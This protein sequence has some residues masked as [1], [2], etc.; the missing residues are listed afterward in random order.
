MSIVIERVEAATL[1]L[2]A[3]LEAHHQDMEHAS[4]PESRHALH[5]DG[6]LTPQVRLFA[7]YDAAGR[8]VATGALATLDDD[9]EE[10]KSMR[11]DPAVRGQGYGSAMLD[12]LRADA[13]VR[14][15]RRLS[16]ETGSADFFLRADAEVRGIRRLSLETGSADFFLPARSLYARAGF[17]ECGPFGRYEADPYSTFMTL[18]LPASSTAPPAHT[19]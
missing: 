6:L 14:G 15:I 4:P 2:A 10:L 12:F 17:S 13:E 1:S 8:P 18:A 3:F 11:T 16:L 19:R 5:I 7:A 9:H